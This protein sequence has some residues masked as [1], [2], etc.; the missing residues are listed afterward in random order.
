MAPKG[1]GKEKNKGGKVMVP[2]KKLQN[3]PDLLTN[4]DE[5]ASS[6]ESTK[7]KILW[8]TFLVIM[9]YLSFEVFIRL[10][11]KVDDSDKSEF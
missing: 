1:V 7:S 6:E 4:G 8:M 5:D 3:V 2:R 10:G 11:S 9:F